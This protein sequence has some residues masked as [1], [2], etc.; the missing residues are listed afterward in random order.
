[1]NE[2]VLSSAA[3]WQKYEQVFAEAQ[4]VW[5]EQ[6]APLVE[7]V[8][9]FRAEEPSGF[10]GKLSHAFT[11]A[12]KISNIERNLR[13]MDWHIGWQEKL[14]RGHAQEIYQGLGKAVL[15]ASGNAA[16][17]ALYASLSDIHNSVQ[18]AIKAVGVAIVESV[19]ASEME[20]LDMVANNKVV[21]FLSYVE[22]DEAKDSIQLAA[23]AIDRLN[24]KLRDTQ[25][26]EAV[27]VTDLD[28]EN[29]LDLV[30]DMWEGGFAGAFTSYLNLLQLDGAIDKM[31]D[32]QIPL[33][34]LRIETETGLRALEITSVRQAARQDAALDKLLR[35]MSPYLPEDTAAAL[36]SQRPAPRLSDLRRG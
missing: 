32:M 1:M 27:V 25:K 10:F 20:V 18:H 31:G 13:A 12:T 3:T 34:D 23:Q 30:V 14:L 17:K 33:D 26:L 6:R 36:D 24:A 15:D 11:G 35:A 28:G 16:D 22:T 19:D 4:D 7:Q 9:A 2:Y 21:S 8:A 5:R 29:T